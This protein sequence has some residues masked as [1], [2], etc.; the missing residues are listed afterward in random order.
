M[1]KFLLQISI[2][3]NEEVHF[4]FENIEDVIIYLVNKAKVGK[5]ISNIIV[6]TNKIDMND[7]KIVKLKKWL[8]TFEKMDNSKAIYRRENKSS[9]VQVGFGDQIFRKFIFYN[10]N[11]SGSSRPF[12]SILCNDYTFSIIPIDYNDHTVS[13]IYDIDTDDE[14]EE[15]EENEENDEDTDFWKNNIVSDEIVEFFKLE[16]NDIKYMNVMKLVTKY[17]MD[18]KMVLQKNKTICL[19]SEAGKKFNTLLQPPN[20]ENL[21]FF[22][23]SVYIRHHFK[24][25]IMYQ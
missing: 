17:I 25:N 10:T 22:N 1:T 21:S 14:C 19:T 8:N 9:K 15:N 13:V 23:L 3:H 2:C 5:T 12:I 11:L 24:A 6:S 7:E 4:L 20:P 18:N 16:T